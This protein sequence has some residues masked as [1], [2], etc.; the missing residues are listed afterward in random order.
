MTVQYNFRSME[1]ADVPEVMHLM[2]SIPELSLRD[3]ETLEQLRLAVR[4]N[5]P[6]PQVAT[7]GD[8]IVAG[9][10]LLNNSLRGELLHLFV[11]PSHRH[12]GIAGYL[13]QQSLERFKQSS[14]V[15]RIFARVLKGNALMDLTL[16]K[17][18]F[19]HSSETGGIIT[20]YT[21]DL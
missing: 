19:R 21:I 3:Y 2:S 9:C 12:L 13:I 4:L 8:A 1:E 5:Y 17:A 16:L 15:T 18:G 6:C 20:A 11:H 14:T 7:Y 10:F